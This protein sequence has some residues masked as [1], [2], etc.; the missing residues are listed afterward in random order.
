MIIAATATAIVSI[1]AAVK[2]RSADAAAVKAL[3]K[4]LR[5]E[6]ASTAANNRSIE[7]ATKFEALK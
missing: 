4:S 1:Y 2:A 5:A 6:N 7:T 3:E